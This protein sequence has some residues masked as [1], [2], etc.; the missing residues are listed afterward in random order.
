MRIENMN[1]KYHNILTMRKPSIAT[2][3]LQKRREEKRREKK[4]KENQSRDV[5]IETAFI[6]GI[7]A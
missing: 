6:L 2:V 5:K 1:Q 4:R 3:E 7:E